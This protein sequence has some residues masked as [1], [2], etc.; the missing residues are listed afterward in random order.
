MISASK[1][2]TPAE[3]KREQR[4]RDK[5]KEEQRRKMLLAYQLKLDVYKGTAA[6]IDQIKAAT[7][8]E[9]PEDI[10]SRLIHNAARLEP[11]QLEE[12]IGSP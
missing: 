9:E 10:I 11:A 1:A 2:K 3:R 8:I 4:A 12:L 5:L 7:G 6:C